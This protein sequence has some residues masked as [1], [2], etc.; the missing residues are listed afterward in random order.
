V[1]AAARAVPDVPTAIAAIRQT[2]A[3]VNSKELIIVFINL[4]FIS[5]ISFFLGL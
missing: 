4:V 1:S 2:N 5:V 3:Q